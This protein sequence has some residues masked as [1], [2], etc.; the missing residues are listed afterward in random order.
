MQGALH[1]Q[2]LAAGHQWI[3]RRLLQRDA[4]RAAHR[5]AFADDVVSGYQ[6]APGRRAQQR[7]EDAHDGGLAGAVW[8]QEAVDFPAV[9]VQVEP[10]YRA[11]AALVLAYEPVDLDGGGGRGRRRH[12]D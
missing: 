8:T 1:P 9:D 12:G 2:E 11:H 5:V 6:R 3:D 4:D 10:V 7:G